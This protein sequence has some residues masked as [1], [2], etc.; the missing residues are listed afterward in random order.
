[1]KYGVMDGV[2]RGTKEELFSDAQRLGFDGV[3]LWNIN[4]DAINELKIL[5][6]KT[7]VAVASVVCGPQGL[8]SLNAEERKSAGE[9]LAGVIKRCETVGADVI[10]VPFFG[11]RNL[12]NK[13]AVSR[14]VEFFKEC[15]K[16]A[17]KHKVTLALEM[18]MDAPCSLELVKKIGSEYVKVYYDV[19][20]ATSTGYDVVSEI[21][22]LVGQIAQFHIK[23][24]NG[25]L[26]DGKVPLEAACKAIKEINFNGYLVLETPSTDDPPKA[27]E[28]NLAYL[29]KCLGF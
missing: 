26:G 10:L 21:K 18:A 4:E 7:G 2:L 3:E 19:G 11:M 8:D 23:D 13:E 25:Q 29:K 9:V 22:L 5:S 24:T 1:M 17:E 16:P 12:D 20:N 6:K 27:A 15:A 14:A 28:K